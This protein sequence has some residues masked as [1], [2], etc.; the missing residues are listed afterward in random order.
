M[1]GRGRNTEV[2]SQLPWGR[3]TGNIFLLFTAGGRS[4]AALHLHLWE[5]ELGKATRWVFSLIDPA[6]CPFTGI[7]LSHEYNCLWVLWTL[8][9]SAQIWV[10]VG[11]PEE[12]P[13]LVPHQWLFQ[14][15]SHF[16]DTLL[17]IST[18]SWLWLPGVNTTTSW[19]TL[20]LMSLSNPK[21]IWIYHLHFLPFY[22]S[23]TGDPST[24]KVNFP[25]MFY[26]PIPQAFHEILVID[27]F[28]SPL[29]F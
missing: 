15:S 13:L 16:S 27:Y 3:N 14:N 2:L 5:G 10:A 8:L 29:H 4:S 6:T 1:R 9:S 11:S 12:C 26:I 24:S 25:A 7:N 18:W 17:F 21:Q 22:L 23:E 28:L 19:T 20:L